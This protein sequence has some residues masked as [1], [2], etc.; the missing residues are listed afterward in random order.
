V[1][2][3]DFKIEA[4]ELSEANLST[5]IESD[6]IYKEETPN[7][8]RENEF[9]FTAIFDFFSTC[10]DYVLCYPISFSMWASFVC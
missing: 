7:F 6:K 4:F 5:R 9:S 3:K 2:I 8:R 10:T 1:K